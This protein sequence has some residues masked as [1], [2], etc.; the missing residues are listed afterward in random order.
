MLA[1]PF[2]YMQAVYAIYGVPKPAS[3]APQND[4]A[5]PKPARQEHRVKEVR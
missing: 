5:P 4:E 1:L 3:R 2:T